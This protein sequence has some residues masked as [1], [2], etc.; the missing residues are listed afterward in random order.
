MRTRTQ[1]LEDLQTIA[2]DTLG[3]RGSLD[4]SSQL[5]EDLGLDSLRAL[6]LL[7]AVEN[8]LRV[9]LTPADEAGLVTVG[10]LLTAIEGRLGEPAESA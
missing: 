10:D 9:R 7:V 6:S 1:L 5:V 8:R 2:A 4:E 3:W